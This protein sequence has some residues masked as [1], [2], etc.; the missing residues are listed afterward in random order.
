MLVQVSGTIQSVAPAIAAV[1][2]SALDYNFVPSILGR[3]GVGL[4]VAAFVPLATDPPSAMNYAAAVSALRGLLPAGA[5][6]VVARC[7]REAKLHFDVWG[8]PAGDL[9]CMRAVKRALDPGDV[10]N[11]GR[12]VV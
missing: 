12:F 9:D 5:S 6:A 10:L 3:C 4:L 2:R 1:E 11:R 7:P 8:E